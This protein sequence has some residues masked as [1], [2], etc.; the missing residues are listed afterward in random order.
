MAKTYLEE[1]CP[2][3]LT[4]DTLTKRRA[5]YVFHWRSRRV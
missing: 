1:I 2:K 5:N 4:R 3:F